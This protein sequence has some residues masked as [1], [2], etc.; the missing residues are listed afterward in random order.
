VKK[1]PVD[2]KPEEGNEEEDHDEHHLQM[3]QNN[4]A[5]VKKSHYFQGP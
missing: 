2:Y 4:L 5:E 3:L 1:L